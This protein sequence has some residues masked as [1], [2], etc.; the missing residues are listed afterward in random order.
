MIAIAN[1]EQ[2]STADDF[3]LAQCHPPGLEHTRTLGFEAN[4][5]GVPS[6]LYEMRLYGNDTTTPAQ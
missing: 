1:K 4:W 5:W 6:W 3:K 2:A